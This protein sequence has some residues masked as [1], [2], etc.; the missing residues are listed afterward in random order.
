MQV[1]A[2]EGREAAAPTATFGAL[3]VMDVDEVPTVG[4][5]DLPEI[6]ILEGTRMQPHRGAKKGPAQEDPLGMALLEQ[7]ASGKRKRSEAR[8]VSM[9]QE[10]HKPLITGAGRMYIPAD[11]PNEVRCIRCTKRDRLCHDQANEVKRGSKQ[12]TA[13]HEC[14]SKKQKCEWPTMAGARRD[15]SDG[16]DDADELESDRPKPPPKKRAKTAAP[17]PTSG[18]RG[19]SKPK[20][21]KAAIKSA[22]YVHS[23]DEGSDAELAELQ[24]QVAALKKRAAEKKKKAAREREEREEREAL[25]RTDRAHEERAQELGASRVQFTSPHLNAAGKWSSA[26]SFLI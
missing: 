9:K 26:Y 23:S 8:D 18:G 19:A 11:E 7:H 20:S 25:E 6:E 24:R 3:D 15:G 10:D 2:D 21:K 16:D 14:A 13:C 1:H 17:R 12:A 5:P 4:N 22:E